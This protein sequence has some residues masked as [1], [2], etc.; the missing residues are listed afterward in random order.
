ML[1]EPLQRGCVLLGEGLRD[2][3]D[4]V[5]VRRGVRGAVHVALA[6]DLHRTE[7]PRDRGGRTHRGREVG[8]RRAVPSEHDAVLFCATQPVF[9]SHALSVQ[10]LPSSQ[11]LL[12]LAAHW[13]SLQPSPVEQAL[14]SSHGLVLLA[15][16]QP[17]AGSQLSSVHGLPSSQLIA[18][19]AVQLPSLH[20]S[21]VVHRLPS[22]QGAVLL[23]W[24]QPPTGLQASV[25]HGLPSSHV[26]TTPGLQTPPL[27]ASPAVQALPSP[28]P[29]YLAGAGRT[30]DG[31]LVY[32]ID[33][34]QVARDW[35]GEQ[36]RRMLPGSRPPG[37]VGASALDQAIAHHQAGDLGAAIAELARGRGQGDPERAPAI[38][39][40][41]AGAWPPLRAVCVC[42]GGGVVGQCLF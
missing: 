30:R 12:P 22:S 13:P 9:G 39:D 6:R 28:S 14:P 20:T 1:I 27:H 40:S 37:P 41:G 24:L 15:N 5:R 8:L 29:P 34:E 21:E 32:C 7:V 36:W 25:V 26:M 2:P 38:A 17:P 18:L 3:D 11:F 42:G 19:P 23:T 31:H 4:E 35:N 10:A 16:L 33:A